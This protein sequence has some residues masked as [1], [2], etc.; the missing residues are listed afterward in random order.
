MKLNANRSDLVQ[1]RRSKAF[2]TIS[3]AEKLI[4]L[5]MLSVAMNRIYYSGFYIVY[6]LMLVDNKNF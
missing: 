5:N 3:D 2:E 4:E 6:A 1:Y